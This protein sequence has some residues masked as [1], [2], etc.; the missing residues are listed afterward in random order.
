MK[1]QKRIKIKYS[2]YAGHVE[3]ERYL[4]TAG[5]A[6]FDVTD[7]FSRLP[8]DVQLAFKA[9]P[10]WEKVDKDVP[11]RGIVVEEG[12]TNYSRYDLLKNAHSEIATVPSPIIFEMSVRDIRVLQ[13]KKDNAP[14]YCFVEQDS[15]DMAYAIFGGEVE[16]FTRGTTGPVL[17]RMFGIPVGLIGVASGALDSLERQG[18]AHLFA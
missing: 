12:E 9:W 14:A 7:A 4:L 8:D 10:A 11:F 3:A 1:N 16:L 13:F 5:N 18:L 15:L 6:L 2:Y 17:L